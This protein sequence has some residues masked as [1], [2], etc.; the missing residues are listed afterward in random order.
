MYPCLHG[1]SPSLCNENGD[2]KSSGDILSQLIDK[3]NWMCEFKMLK[4]ALKH[5]IDKIPKEMFIMP[6]ISN[7]YTF[8]FQTWYYGFLDEKC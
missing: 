4:T 7:K 6:R 3:R 5:A 2:I 1:S 8:H